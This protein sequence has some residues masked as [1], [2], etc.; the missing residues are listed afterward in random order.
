MAD[1]E[2]IYE[3]EGNFVFPLRGLFPPAALRE[4]RQRA[5]AVFS[6]LG[7]GEVETL[8]PRAKIQGVAPDAERLR[9]EWFDPWR[10]AD[11]TPLLARCGPLDQL[12]YPPQLR[13]IR[14]SK[15]RVPWHQDLAYQGSMQRG[16]EHVA[17][18]FV[19]LEEEPA[20]HATIEF[21]VGAFDR[22]LEHHDAGVFHNALDDDRFP[23]RRSFDLALGDALF[24]GAL[25]PHRTYL[26]AG[27]Q[28]ERYSLEY[29]L[30]RRDGVIP[31]KDYF[32]LR[33]L[34]FYQATP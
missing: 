2:G 12:T 1:E 6:S 5:S 13:F 10:V 24:F 34:A 17:T 19:P 18:V 9:E 20:D 22:P 25:I 32:D 15:H 8:N 16:H 23:E 31:G 28:L 7:D 11:L 27:C 30:T 33:S 26:P 21:G 29:R 4:A 14:E 3:S